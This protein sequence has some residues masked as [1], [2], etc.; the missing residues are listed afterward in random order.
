VCDT[1]GKF[2]KEGYLYQEYDMFCSK[3]CF[4]DAYGQAIFDNADDEELY[5][6]DLVD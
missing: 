4:I 2:I 1:C 3:E 5:W 6:V